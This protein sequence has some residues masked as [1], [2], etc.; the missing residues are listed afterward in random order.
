MMEWRNG[1]KERKKAYACLLPFYY[2]IT[3]V[4]FN[5]RKCSSGVFL[6]PSTLS[7]RE[8]ENGTHLMSSLLTYLAFFT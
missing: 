2:L 4:F 1:K 8:G 6:I 3:Q 7:L 5:N